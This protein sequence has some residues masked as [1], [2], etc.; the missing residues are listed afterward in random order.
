MLDARSYEV[1][2]IERER[3]EARK[4]GFGKVPVRQ[5]KPRIKQIKKPW[6]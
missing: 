1:A 4:R 2:K 3:A 5:K 6:G